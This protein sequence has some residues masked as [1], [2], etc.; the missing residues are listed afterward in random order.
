MI[1]MLNEKCSLS[2]ENVLI[3][4]F[5]VH[6]HVTASTIVNYAQFLNTDQSIIKFNQYNE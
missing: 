2:N 4:R 1:N 3:C 6:R 5:C